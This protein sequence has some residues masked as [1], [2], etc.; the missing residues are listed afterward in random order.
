MA[1]K[2]DCLAF[3][4]IDEDI[5]MYAFPRLYCES[6]TKQARV[7]I[8][9]EEKRKMRSILRVLILWSRNKKNEG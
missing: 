7:V 2:Q 9:H 6:E 4:Q 5:E 8:M 3:R 1:M